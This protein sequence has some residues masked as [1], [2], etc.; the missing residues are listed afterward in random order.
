MSPGRASLRGRTFR[1]NLSAQA[2]H[3]SAI[4]VQVAPLSGSRANLA[5]FSHSAAAAKSFGRI[6]DLF[7]LRWVVYPPGHGRGF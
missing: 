6:H 1:L 5:I 3:R 4:R 2:S 7:L